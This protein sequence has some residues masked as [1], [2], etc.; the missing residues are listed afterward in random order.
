M[1]EYSIYNAAQHHVFRVRERFQAGP[2]ECA[3]CLL[4]RWCMAV[5][6]VLPRCVRDTAHR[7]GAEAGA[8]LPPPTHAAS[9]CA[10]PTPQGSSDF[11]SFSCRVEPVR[12]THS[13]PD[14]C[15]LIL[16]SEYGNIVHTGDWRIEEQ[17]LDGHHFDRDAFEGVAK[18]GVALMMSDSTN[19]LA[20]G[21]T[22][23]EQLVEENLIRKVMEHEGKGRVVS[24][25]FASNVGRLGSIRKAAQAAGRSIAFIGRS[26][27][28]YL[29]AAQR[30]GFAPFHPNELIKQDDIGSVDANKLLIVTTGSQVRSSCAACWLCC[31]C[32]SCVHECCDARWRHAQPWLALACQI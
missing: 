18:E 7:D 25:Q 31:C 26:L 21:R 24:T 16:R 2:F 9:T 12:V 13:I 32:V 17:P 3:A 20:P 15:G 22:V 8:A 29:E 14:S 19:V 4:W 5:Q 23:S 1:R 30:A 11:F 6:V 28:S 10:H 27:H